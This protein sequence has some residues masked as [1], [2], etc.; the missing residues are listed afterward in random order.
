MVWSVLNE[1]LNDRKFGIEDMLPI[2]LLFSDVTL[3]S[4]CLL[5]V[6]NIGNDIHCL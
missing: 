5:Y 3:L 2:W 1:A 6:P 4:L